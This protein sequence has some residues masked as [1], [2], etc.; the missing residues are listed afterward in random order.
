MLLLPTLMT[1]ILINSTTTTIAAAPQGDNEAGYLSKGII[2]ETR[3][4]ILSYQSGKRKTQFLTYVPHGSFHGYS[5]LLENKYDL[6]RIVTFVFNRDSSRVWTNAW[7]D[8]GEYA[9][10][11]MS[12]NGKLWIHLSLG[13]SIACTAI[14][15]KPPKKNQK[16]RRL[17]LSCYYGGNSQKKKIY[18]FLNTS[19]VNDIMIVPPHIRP[20][21]LWRSSLRHVPKDTIT[22]AEVSL[23]YNDFTIDSGMEI[24]NIVE[25][26]G[27][28]DE[29][30]K[31]E[32][33]QENNRAPSCQVNI[34]VLSNGA[35]DENSIELNQK[36][37]TV[38]NCP[39]PSDDQI[40]N[41]AISIG[42]QLNKNRT[43]S[44]IQ[45]EGGD[46][47]PL[48]LY[49]A[50]TG[51]QQWD[52]SGLDDGDDHSAPQL[53][54][55]VFQ[56]EPF[57]WPGI[58]INYTRTVLTDSNEFIN[59]TTISLR[60]RLFQIQGFITNESLNALRE[61]CMKRKQN[62]SRLD[63]DEDSSSNDQEAMTVN[64]L[65]TDLL[66]DHYLF[67]P[68]RVSSG[69]LYVTNQIKLALPSFSNLLLNT[70]DSLHLP[71]Y[72]SIS[73][74]HVLQLV[75]YPPNG[76]F[77]HHYDTI[78][79]P[80]DLEREERGRLLTMFMYLNNVEND[81][82]TNFP[83]TFNNDDG[84]TNDIQEQLKQSYNVDSIRK[85]KYG[86][87]IQPKEKTSIMWYNLRPSDLKRDPFSYHG[88]CSTNMGNYKLG[89]NVW[90]HLPKE[91]MKNG[92]K[93]SRNKQE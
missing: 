14:V 30:V 86:I 20:F 34:L 69:L 22:I 80:Y 59:I 43:D 11:E 82:H 6:D 9:N 66:V 58:H 67:S 90:F 64:H 93:R 85:C 84:S 7:E 38:N 92:L 23:D 1:L 48:Q 47:A 41:I 60:P 56:D 26:N 19:N 33:L 49:N 27:E 21:A 52:L 62:N 17:W 71:Q 5:M 29:E 15:V 24:E 40:V 10:Y 35:G 12:E 54:M 36:P 74:P 76:R 77:A 51:I 68:S 16:S 2:N 75:H 45:E 72:D 42:Y 79:D 18:A 89:A 87:N 25:V 13:T 44:I 73:S 28:V 3:A 81:G 31:E 78:S 65:F 50:Y 88:G 57:I 53:L 91:I 61:H 8:G 4:R 70:K 32:N 37:M 39:N 46:V 83:F 55:A 63:P